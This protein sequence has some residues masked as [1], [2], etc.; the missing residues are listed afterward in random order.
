VTRRG[1]SF[2]LGVGAAAI[3]LLGCKINSS[4]YH[5]ELKVEVETPEG[6]RS[7]SSV[8]G[9]RIFSQ[10][11]G[12][13]GLGGGGNLQAFGEAAAVD[14]PDGRTLFVLLRSKTNED[15][16]ASVH[17]RNSNLKRDQFA[18]LD[19]YMEALRYDRIVHP[20]RRWIDL[21]NQPPIDD[22]PLLVTF[23]DANDP[24]SVERVDPDDLAA[25]FG[26]GYRLRSLTVQGTDELVSKGLE[27]RLAWLPNHRG[28]LKP[29]PPVT[30]DDPNDP[31]LRL[32]DTGPFQLR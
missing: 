19:Q 22:Y 14:L 25:T 13:E 27:K 6:V 3:A 31:D 9:V 17:V 28:T 20:L 1:F 5:Y 8:I 29:N 16:A 18:S 7:G 4:P 12:T 30:M 2:L 21:P 11:K 24:K 23:K 15:W 10:V 26:A 32:L